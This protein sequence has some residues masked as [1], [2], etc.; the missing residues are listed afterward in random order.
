[1]GRRSSKTALILNEALGSF[2]DAKGNSAD[3]W[4]DELSDVFELGFSD[5]SLTG[6]RPPPPNADSFFLQSLLCSF[7]GTLQQ[8]FGDGCIGTFGRRDYSNGFPVP[9][10]L[11]EAY[12]PSWFRCSWGGG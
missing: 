4:H 6:S 3:N 5:A 2:D 9:G 12:W 8:L 11:P 7:L 10:A 1:M